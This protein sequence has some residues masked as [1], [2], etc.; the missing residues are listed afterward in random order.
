[1]FALMLVAGSLSGWPDVAICSL[2]YN[3]CNHPP[4]SIAPKR[5]RT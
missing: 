3:L 4:C 5:K 2:P 1:M